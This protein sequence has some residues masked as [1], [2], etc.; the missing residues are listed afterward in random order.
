[1]HFCLKIS[2]ENKGY[3][4]ISTSTLVSIY[5][6]FWNIIYNLIK[7]KLDVKSKYLY[8]MQI[9]F[10]SI[11]SLPL[12]LIIIFFFIHSIISGYFFYILFIFLSFFFCGAIW[13]SPLCN[14]LN[15]SN[16]SCNFCGFLDMNPYTCIFCSSG[17]L[18][19]YCDSNNKCYCQCCFYYG[20]ETKCCDCTICCKC[21]CKCCDC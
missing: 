21:C 17:R 8:I 4:L 11:I 15:D 12:I 19:S 20:Y 18:G 16:I 1:M 2:E 7:G 5:L 3:D 14:Y 9:I 10:S 13:L 6:F